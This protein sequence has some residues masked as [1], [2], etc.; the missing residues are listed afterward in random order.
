MPH[1]LARARSNERARARCLASACWKANAMESTGTLIPSA[2]LQPGD[3]GYMHGSFSMGSAD[4][5]E[6]WRQLEEQGDKKA[7]EYL[8]NV[9]QK[10]EEGSQEPMETD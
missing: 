3:R 2:P 7:V 8:D 5:D 10:R 6:K 9:K 1:A 4:L